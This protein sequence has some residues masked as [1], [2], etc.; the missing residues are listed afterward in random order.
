MSIKKAIFPVAG[1][2]TRFLPVTKAQ[3]KEMLP[4][5][6][7]P[8]IQYV[9][10]EAVQSGIEDFLFITGKDKRPLEDYFDHSGELEYHLEKQG[11]T[12]LLELVRNIACMCQI[13]YV[14]QKKPLGLGHAVWCAKQHVG[15]EHFAVLLGDDI[16]VAHEPC[17][18]QMIEVYET[19][20]RPVVAIRR[21]PRDEVSSYGII[22]G[23][24]LGGGL[25]EVSD[26]VEKP[27]PEDA[28]SDLAVIGRYI[29]PPEIFP[30]LEDLEPGRGGEIQLT[31]A[32]RVLAQ[33]EPIIGYEFK[34]IRYDVGTP[35]GLLIATIEMA[36]SREDL[37]EELEQY[38]ADLVRRRNLT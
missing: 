17:L 1:L 36:L 15:D 12:D 22:Q 26:L 32:L 14:R 9:V 28:P 34:G 35:K 2:G 8:A 16:V 13:H 20:K 37:G 21:V 29:L 6:D 27:A 31:D 7:K 4:I 23:K 18:K 33:A 10:E 11:K 30:V 24:P 19:T 25:W 5:V 3:P 38:L